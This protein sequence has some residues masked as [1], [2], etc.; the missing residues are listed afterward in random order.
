MRRRLRKHGEDL[1]AQFESPRG[2]HVLLLCQLL[3]PSTMPPSMPLNRIRMLVAAAVD[4]GRRLRGCH[5]TAIDA[6]RGRVQVK[7]EATST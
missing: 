4:W 3:P 1:R 7:R 5:C 6:W 2:R